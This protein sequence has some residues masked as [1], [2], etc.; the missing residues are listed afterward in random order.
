MLSIDT[1]LYDSF[2]RQAPERIVSET[3][4]YLAQLLSGRPPTTLYRVLLLQ[5]L[6]QL[7]RPETTLTNTE[8]LEI[9]AF[10]MGLSQGPA[11]AATT[12]QVQPILS[13]RLISRNPLVVQARVQ[14]NDGRL[15]LLRLLRLNQGVASG[16]SRE[17]SYEDDRPLPTGGV[18]YKAVATFTNSGELTRT[19]TLLPQPML[20]FGC[21]TVNP[22]L[23]ASIT[24]LPTAE[25]LPVN[26]LVFDSPVSLQYMYVWVPQSAGILTKIENKQFGQTN[27]LPSF[28]P[29]PMEVQNQP[30]TLWSSYSR[31]KAADY[32]L[33]FTLTPTP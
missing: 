25:A 31:I 9:A 20:H 27:L 10:F 8:R 19:L 1:S 15:E 5:A 24:Q 33:T 29:E 22:A 13:L 11:Q 12:A 3:T 18:T 7:E 16:T 6:R 23:A 21:L 26:D 14:E 30:G 2:L 28:R 32:Q 4:R 17:L